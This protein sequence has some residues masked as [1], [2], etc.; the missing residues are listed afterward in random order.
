MTMTNKR[1]RM[2]YER[3]YALGWQREKAGIA[4]NGYESD[5]TAQGRAE[6]RYAASIGRDVRWSIGGGA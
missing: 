3:E 2:A 5:W 4:P 1:D 6:F